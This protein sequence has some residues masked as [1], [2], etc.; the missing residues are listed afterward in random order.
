MRPL[1]YLTLA[2][3]LIVAPCHAGD[4]RQDRRTVVAAVTRLYAF[5]LHPERLTPTDI[6]R[7]FPGHYK[8]FLAGGNNY[9]YENQ[10]RQG[11]ARLQLYHLDLDARGRPTG[12]AALFLNIDSDRVCLRQQELDRLFHDVGAQ[13]RFPPA[14]DAWGPQTKRTRFLDYGRLNPARPDMISASVH[15]ADDCV[16]LISL[17]ARRD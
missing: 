17:D 14:L 6:E 15:L 8:R 12:R 7:A 10:G 4:G 2:G 1:Y 3:L 5:A 16:S 9:G 11:V 13:P